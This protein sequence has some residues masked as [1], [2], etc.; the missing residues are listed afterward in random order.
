MLYSWPCSD[1]G[2]QSVWNTT[3]SGQ[4]PFRLTASPPAADVVAPPADVVAP[5]AEVVA[6]PAAEVV[7]PAVVAPP[8]LLLLL[9]L[10]QA[11]TSMEAASAPPTSRRVFIWLV[12]SSGVLGVSGVGGA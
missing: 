9:L 5:P 3:V 12:F 6:R 4:A 11:A 7:A 10:P 8:P 1:S 2:F